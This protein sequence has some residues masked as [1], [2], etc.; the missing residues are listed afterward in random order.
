M[1][2]H[3]TQAIKVRTCVSKLWTLES[4]HKLVVC[5]LS[6]RRLWSDARVFDRRCLEVCDHGSE[7]SGTAA[8]SMCLR[9]QCR[10][11]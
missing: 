11:G 9:L 8:L 1:C 5:A 4:V 6:V 3:K 7:L 10:S 2:F